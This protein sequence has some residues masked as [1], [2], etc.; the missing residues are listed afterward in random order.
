MRRNHIYRHSHTYP[1]TYGNLRQLTLQNMF[2]VL[3][4][5]GRPKNVKRACNK[6]RNIKISPS[7]IQVPG[8]DAQGDSE[9]SR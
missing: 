5:G 3:R 8:R 9:K 2:P 1:P 4:N 7:K 6:G